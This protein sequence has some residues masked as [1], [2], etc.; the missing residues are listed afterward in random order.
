MISPKTSQA[1]Y[2]QVQ[3]LAQASVDLEGI[4]LAAKS[5]NWPGAHKV[6]RDMSKEAADLAHETIKVI[7]D[8]GGDLT[9]NYPPTTEGSAAWVGYPAMFEAFLK[10]QADAQQGWK[11]I[12]E[13]SETNNDGDIESLIDDYLDSGVKSIMQI[14]RWIMKLGQIGMDMSALMKFDSKREKGGW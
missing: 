2:S 7:R 5:Y 1:L 6:A 9:C 3:L 4:S 12:F 11:D 10:I 8:Y 13:I 14:R